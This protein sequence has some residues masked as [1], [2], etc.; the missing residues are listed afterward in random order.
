MAQWLLVGFYLTAERS[1]RVALARLANDLENVPSS[2][3]SGGGL[4]PRLEAQLIAMLSRPA[5]HVSHAS[6][7]D[8][9]VASRPLAFWRSSASS[10][11][12]MEKSLKR[13]PSTERWLGLRARQASISAASVSRLCAS[14]TFEAIFQI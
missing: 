1:D 9:T 11:P 7:A 5:T 3:P 14:R 10:P 12:N 6:A 4:S 2:E 8:R 13:T